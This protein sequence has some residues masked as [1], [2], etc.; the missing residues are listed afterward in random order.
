MIWHR[1][2]FYFKS[3]VLLSFQDQICFRNARNQSTITNSIYYLSFISNYVRN[4]NSTV[5]KDY[6][7]CWL[8]IPSNL[9]H[10]FQNLIL[11]VLITLPWLLLE[12]KLMKC[13]SSLKNRLLA[14]RPQLPKSTTLKQ[15][16]FIHR[17]PHFYTRKAQVTQ[18]IH[19]RLHPHNINRESRTEISE[20]WML[21][22]KKHN[23]WRAM[24]QRTTEGT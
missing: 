1:Q 4:W 17:D 5:L 14:A 22:I 8:G 6:C 24:Q 19:L 20:V 15:V 7:S 23:S 12:P 10:I 11:P 9:T 3:E 2:W 21:T 13:N 16:K 18:A